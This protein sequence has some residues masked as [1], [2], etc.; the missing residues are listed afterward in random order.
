MEHLAVLAGG[1]LDLDVKHL[2]EVLT[3]AVGSSSLDTTASRRD[4]ALNG[5]REK[6]SG[7]LLVLRLDTGDER[8]SEELL[9]DAAVKVE[10][11]EDL[12]LGLS[13]GEERRVALLPEELAR[14][15]ERLRVLELPT[16]DRVPLVET[17]REIAVG[18]DP[19]GVV[20]R[21]GRPVRNP[22]LLRN[23]PTATYKDT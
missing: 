18:L 19:L 2:G 15:E 4:K 12:L 11:L 16:D 10:D 20:W 17:E 21:C 22:G 7:E 5:R 1:I 23:G 9:V 3:E 6:A 14:P 8:D 13:P